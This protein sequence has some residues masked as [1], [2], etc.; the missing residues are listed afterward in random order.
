VPAMSD[1]TDAPDARSG[2]PRRYYGKY[3]GLV[4]D[5]AAQDGGAHRG[6][7]KV[8][9]PGILEEAPGGEGSQPIEVIAAPAF[10]PGFFFVPEVDAHVWVEF[11]AGDINHPIWTGAWYPNDAPPADSEGN[12]PDEHKKIIRTPSGQVL[13]LDDTSDGE[14]L[15]ILM[16][17]DENKNTITMNKDGIVIECQQQGGTSTITMD[18]NGVKIEFSQSSLSLTSDTIEL[19]S[20]NLNLTADAKITLKAPDVVAEVDNAMDVK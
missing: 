8:K 6:Q 13:H 4:L 19:K 10:L 14:K 3:A 12:A 20:T 11:V 18:T 5:N 15:V 17:K 9:V 2:A 7:I 16:I 1:F